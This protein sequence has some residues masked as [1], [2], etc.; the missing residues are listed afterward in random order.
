MS[1]TG[2]GTCISSSSL[3]TAGTGTAWLGKLHLAFVGRL[4]VA[5]ATPSGYLGDEGQ[6]EE[7]EE[8][9]LSERR[10]VAR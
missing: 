6:D 7:Q 5:T 9:D 1:E 2:A 3:T 8:D 4:A 10:S